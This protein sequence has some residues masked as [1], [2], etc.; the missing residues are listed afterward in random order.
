MVDQLEPYQK[1]ND[2][3]LKSNK[4]QILCLIGLLM[5]LLDVGH[6]REECW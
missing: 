5:G 3:D 6:L 2:L 1:V 4:L